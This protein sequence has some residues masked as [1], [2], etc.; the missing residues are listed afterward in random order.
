MSS[1]IYLVIGGFHLLREGKDQILNIIDEFKKMGVKKAA[2]THC[3]GDEAISLF[4]KAYNDDF[5][6]VKV[7][8]KLEV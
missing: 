5:V 4:G 8:L 3:T 2:P 1:G 6:K 7:G